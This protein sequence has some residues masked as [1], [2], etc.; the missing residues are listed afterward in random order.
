MGLGV[1]PEMGPYHQKISPISNRHYI[2]IYCG[3]A[4]GEGLEAL[5]MGELGIWL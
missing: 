1:V 3:E 4:H 2:R 5:I